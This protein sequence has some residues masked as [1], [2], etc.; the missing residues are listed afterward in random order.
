MTTAFKSLDDAANAYDALAA[1]VEVLSRDVRFASA[2]EALQPA[3]TGMLANYNITL[4]P[5]SEDGTYDADALDDALNAFP[6]GHA[7][8]VPPERQARLR[9]ML[10][11][12]GRLA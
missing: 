8:G 1:K 2:R 12:M 3:L 11:E 6:P 4:P 9:R 5:L 10:T 7:H